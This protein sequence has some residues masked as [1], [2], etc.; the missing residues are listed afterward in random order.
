MSPVLEQWQRE[1]ETA[2]GG[3]VVLVRVETDPV[4]N[5]LRIAPQFPGRPIVAQRL[6]QEAFV[7]QFIRTHAMS[8]TYEGPEGN[9]HFVLL[10][11]ARAADWE[12]LED[13]I[14]AH[15]FGHLWLNATGFRSLPMQQ[16]ALRDC[17]AIH[18]NDIVHHILLRQEA[19]R[20]GIDAMAY[21]LNTREA[22]MKSV[23]GSEAPAL[24]EC[25]EWQ[26][27]AECVDALMGA[28]RWPRLGEFLNLMRT[29]HPRL[30]DRAV[31]LRDLLSPL[32]LWDRSV[33]EYALSAVSRALSVQ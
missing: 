21:W 26:I 32:D 1:I 14:L 29:R 13:S 8:I 17:L 22:W 15:E 31:Q 30:M 25:Q 18:V 12:G 3:L 20:R 10:N 7:V 11:M 9:F 5:V 27:V 4:E 24:D 16:D 33:Y 23:A 2:S 19:R 28:S 6:S